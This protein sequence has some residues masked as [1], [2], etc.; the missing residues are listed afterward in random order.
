MDMYFTPPIVRQD[1]LL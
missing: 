1:I